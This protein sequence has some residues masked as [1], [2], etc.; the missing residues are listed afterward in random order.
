VAYAALGLRADAPATLGCTLRA[1]PEAD[2]KRLEVAELVA[3][4]PAALRG[5]RVGDR[6][7]MVND[8]PA[9]MDAFADATSALVIGTM[10]RF[11]LEGD[12]K[13]RELWV[14]AGVG[15]R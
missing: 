6:I 2:P 4:G 13:R 7:T 11:A 9:T 10:V 3:D 5:L 8:Q 12:D 15:A 14:G 1:V